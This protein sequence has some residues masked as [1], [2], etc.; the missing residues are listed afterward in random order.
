MFELS[1]FCSGLLFCLLWFQSCSPERRKSTPPLNASNINILKSYIHDLCSSLSVC[2]THW[3]LSGPARRCREQSVAPHLGSWRGGP[4]AEAGYPPHCSSGRGMS[5]CWWSGSS[6]GRSQPEQW[7]AGKTRFQLE[8]KL[9]GH[10]LIHASWLSDFTHR[11]SSK[12]EALRMPLGVQSVRSS[13]IE[14]LQESKFN[15]N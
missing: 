2:V 13:L 12:K 7:T 10:D 1:E 11:K 4:P 8:N 14:E 3:W 6:P 5:R 9:P 15:K